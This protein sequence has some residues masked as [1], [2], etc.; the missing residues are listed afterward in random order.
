ML[1]A[2]IFGDKLWGQKNIGNL[3]TNTII[4]IDNQLFEIFIGDKLWGHFY[5]IF[6]SP[7]LLVPIL[8]NNFLS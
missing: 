6:H 4:N 2:I 3:Y 1:I 5:N 7:L 8:S